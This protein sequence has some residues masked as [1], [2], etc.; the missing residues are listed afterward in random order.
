MRLALAV[1]LALA[2]VDA[3]CVGG[4]GATRVTASPALVASATPSSV[5]GTSTTPEPFPTTNDALLE[6]ALLRVDDLGGDW[7]QESLQG[8]GATMADNYYCGRKVRSLTPDAAAIFVDQSGLHPLMIEAISRFET[9]EA[10]AQAIATISNAH[11]GCLDWTSTDGVR[12]TD[13]HT[14][15]LT[16]PNI[17]D[18]AL[19]E[20]ATAQVEGIPGRETGVYVIA[21]QGG[22]IFSIAELGVQDFPVSETEAIAAK[23]L[24]RYTSVMGQ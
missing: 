3:A 20:K 8:A 15:S 14:E 22:T 12:R 5:V 13:W 17:A 10:A 19:V 23:A 7:V 11:S 21:R 9:T 18:E 2:T 24:S 1:V 16:R 4:N 6:S